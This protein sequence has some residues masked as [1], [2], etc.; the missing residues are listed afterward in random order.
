[1]MV[2]ALMVGPVVAQTAPAPQVVTQPP[3]AIL[4]PKLDQELVKITPLQPV[5]ATNFVI[6]KRAYLGK[7]V[8]VKNNEDLSGT[9]ECDGFQR[10]GDKLILEKSGDYTILT[11][12]CNGRPDR[13]IIGTPTMQQ[14]LSMAFKLAAVAAKPVEPVKPAEP[15]RPVAAAPGSGPGSA[16]IDGAPWNANRALAVTTTIANKPVLNLNLFAG[17]DPLSRFGFN[18]GLAQAGSF[19]GSYDLV[20]RGTSYGNYTPNQLDP[21]IMANSFVFTGKLTIT[22]FDAAKNRISGTFSGTATNRGGSK[23]LKIENGRFSD[24]DISAQ[25]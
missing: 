11:I 25:R 21:D 17:T 7:T 16:T 2:L 4:S 22:A 24:I 19:A 18:L 8:V 5:P 13:K 14:K 23:T 12:Q 3:V 6:P 1:M 10:A 9:L 15:V 20:S